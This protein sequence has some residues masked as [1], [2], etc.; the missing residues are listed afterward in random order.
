MF[1]QKYDFEE[2]EALINVFLKKDFKFM[3]FSDP[4][5]LRV[6]KGVLF[7]HDVDMSLNASVELS[8]IEKRKGICSTYFIHQYSRFYNYKSDFSR[9]CINEILN[10]GHE[11]GL[12]FD[13]SPHKI[14]SATDL[15]DALNF[16]KQDLERVTG[17]EIKVFSH[18]NPNSFMLSI[19]N[20]ILAGMINT[21]S[22]SIKD[23]YQYCSDS[24]GKWST[25]IEQFVMQDYNAYQVLTHPV[26]WTPE[27]LDYSGKIRYW[28]DVQREVSIDMNLNLKRN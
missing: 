10:N 19:D 1:N 2:Y 6:N 27:P 20:F 3:R 7:R 12:H 14:S 24:N 28:A 4:D 11:I 16:E 13:R 25:D 8:N 17:R 15:I 18:H 22:R 21:Y 26:W 23:R 9:K 5:I